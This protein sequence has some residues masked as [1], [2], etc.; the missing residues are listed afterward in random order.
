MSCD[1]FQQSSISR[2]SAAAQSITVSYLRLCQRDNN[3]SKMNANSIAQEISSRYI[4]EIDNG[5]PHGQ[6]VDKYLR[7]SVLRLTEKVLI[8][9]KESEL[10]RRCKARM[11]AFLQ[12]C[13]LAVPDDGCDRTK[14]QETASDITVKDGLSGFNNR[15]PNSLGPRMVYPQFRN[16]ELTL[17]LELYLRCLN[18]VNSEKIECVVHLESPKTVRARATSLVRAFV[19]TVGCVRSMSPNLTRLLQVLTMELLA[20][21]TIS[22]GLAKVIRR[23]YECLSVFNPHQHFFSNLTLSNCPHTGVVSEYQ[24]QISFASLAFLSSPEDSAENRLSPL[25][26]SYIK[27][28][29]SNWKDLVENSVLERMLITVLDQK[30]RNIFKTVEFVS[31]GHLLDVCNGYSN[32]LQHIELPPDIG[33]FDPD[34]DIYSICSSSKVVKQAIRDLQREVITVNGHALPPVTSRKELVQLLSQI[35]N[36]RSLFKNGKNGKHKFDR[37]HKAQSCPSFE[38]IPSK[39]LDS[40]GFISSG[41]EGDT[42]GSH[43]GRVPKNGKDKAK[44]R[45][46]RRQSFHLSTIDM[47]TRRLLIASSRTG[48]GGDAYLIVRDLFGGDDVEVVPSKENVLYGRAARRSSIE[49]IVRLASVTIKCHGSYDV[50]PSSMVGDCEPLIQLHTTT[51]ETIRLQEVRASDSDE[52]ISKIDYDDSSDEDVASKLVLQEQ[53]TDRTGWRT[54]SIRPALYEKVEEWNT[55]S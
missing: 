37:V 14:T 45:I 33:G 34:S 51:T 35:L 13:A 50:F 44:K 43:N 29:Q 17:R 11:E 15:S 22:D 20:V 25:I 54:L 12:G 5:S 32:A 24:H 4:G 52:A 6:N 55:P 47:M 27:Y 30:M 19:A 3:T 9:G 36:S 28:L 41:N 10:S 16:S 48:I 42:D 49:I 31:I 1:H 26:I 8:H 7:P 46:S 18:R 38:T 21:E 2:Q 53:Q 40:E 23:E 39:D